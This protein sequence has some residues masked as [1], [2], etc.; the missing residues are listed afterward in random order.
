MQNARH[1]VHVMQ[2]EILKSM[3]EH[4]TAEV[5]C[6]S[7]MQSDMKIVFGKKIGTLIYRSEYVHI[8]GAR[9]MS[10]NDVFEHNGVLIH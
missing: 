2:S 7:R 5:R 3:I 4:R 9:G 10:S 8:M 1:Q 6:S